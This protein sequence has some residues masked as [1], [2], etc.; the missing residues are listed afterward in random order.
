MPKY[1]AIAAVTLDGKIA[2]GPNHPSDWTS[3]ED[4]RFMRSLL[5]KC[6]VIIVGNNTYKIAKKPLTKRNCI[7]F[8]RSEG[9]I[10]RKSGNLMYINPAKVDVKRLINKL[11]YKKIA[12]L[13]GAQTYAYCLKN[14]L[15][16]EIYLTIEPIVFG[17]GINLFTNDIAVE[18]KFKLVSIKKLNKR[19]SLLLKYQ[20]V[21][22]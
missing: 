16:D 3:P 21:D 17:E 6:D 18:A 10:N 8:S 12:L 19:G 14:N 2:K 13:G 7:V 4:K 5:N 9:R 20:K 1:I 22:K 15:L 11:G